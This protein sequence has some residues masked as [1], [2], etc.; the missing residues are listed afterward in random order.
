MKKL[1]AIFLV[2]TA[3]CFAANFSGH[4]SLNGLQPG[5]TK[6]GLFTAPITGT[7]FINGQLSLPVG[8][9]AKGL[10]YKNNN[11]VYTGVAGATGFSIP[12]TQLAAADVI[13]VGVSSTATVDQGLNVIKGDVF[14]G[15]KY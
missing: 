8:S 5:A 9:Q 4:Q 13:T 6:V 7:Y 2:I 10:I 3:I 1:S 14:F 11:A 12:V 15:N